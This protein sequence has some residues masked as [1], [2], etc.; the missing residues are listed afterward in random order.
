MAQE[1]V[2]NPPLVTP[3]QVAAAVA[4]AAVEEHHP[5][6]E[7]GENRK[8]AIWLFLCSEVMFFTVLI[9]AYV[10]ARW[11]DPAPH[12]VLNVQ[13]TAVNTFILLTS[14]FTVVRALSAIQQDKRTAFL[15]NLVLSI[16]FGTIF[17]SIQAYEYHNLSTEGLTLSSSL[18]G[19]AFF[20]LTGFHGAHVVIGIVWLLRTFFRGFNGTYS[21]HENWGV[22]LLGLYWHFVDIVWVLLFVFIYLI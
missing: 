21:S 11:K 1:F 22:E 14:S 20:A 15:R 16:I 17:V 18:F 5:E 8:F 6:I 10:M 12:E 7:A 19:S 2:S 3:P 9:G 4:T 13:L